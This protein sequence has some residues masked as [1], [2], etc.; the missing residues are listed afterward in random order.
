V[1]RQGA[2]RASG[3]TDSGNLRAW[4]KFKERQQHEG[5][6]MHA[7]V[8]D[9]K[10]A[11]ADA[12]MRRKQDIAPIGPD[13]QV[14]RKQDVEVHGAWR[15]SVGTYPP[16]NSLD[17]QKRAKQCLRRML[18]CEAKH[19][20]DIRRSLATLCGTQPPGGLAQRAS[21]EAIGDRPDGL[22]EGGYPVAKVCPE[23]HG[24]EEAVARTWARR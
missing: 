1:L 23:P 24:V 16:Q 13:T 7:R 4:I 6:S 18:A 11:A 17:V 5:A 22:F 3:W 8:R 15:V 10:I 2:Q 21:R 14:L 19:R 9:H 20:V 12:K